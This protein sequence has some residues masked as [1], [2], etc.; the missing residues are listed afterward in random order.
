MSVYHSGYGIGILSTLLVGAGVL[1][2]LLYGPTWAMPVAGA[3][4]AVTLMAAAIGVLV[5]VT[6]N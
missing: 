4:A 3:L 1:A 2:L 6:R 5:S